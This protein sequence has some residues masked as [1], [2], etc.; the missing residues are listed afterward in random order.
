V[1]ASSEQPPN[2]VF[3]PLVLRRREQWIRGMARRLRIQYP[4]ARHHV[5]N[6]ENLQHAVFATVGASNAFLI[7]LAEGTG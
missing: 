2:W 4:G 3:A 5:I 6:R 1:D 7:W